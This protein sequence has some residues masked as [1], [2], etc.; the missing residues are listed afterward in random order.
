MRAAA[1][2]LLLARLAVL[3]RADR[4]VLGAVVGGELG[5]A[6]R[7]DGRSERRD[8]GD[9][10]FAAGESCCEPRAIWVDAAPAIIA[11]GRAAART[12]ASRRA[13]GACAVGSSAIASASRAGPRRS[14]FVTSDAR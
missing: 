13:A 3:V 5:A 12:G 10:S 6:Q 8:P 4:D 9:D 2:V 7:D 11:S 14:G 1:L